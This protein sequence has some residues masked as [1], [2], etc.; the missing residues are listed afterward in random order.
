MSTTSAVTAAYLDHKAAFYDRLIELGYSASAAKKQRQLLAEVADWAGRQ[1]VP[2]EELPSASAEAFFRRRRAR[3]KSNLR[4]PR[5]LEPFLS[6]L[7]HVG[8]VGVSA[9]NTPTD[10]LETFLS[11]YV[12]F[13]RSERGLAPGTARMYS[14]V[15][16]QLASEITDTCGIDWTGLR[17][18]D[19][20]GFATRT[21]KG[22]GVSWSRQVVS[23]LRCLLRYLTL[24]GLTELSLDQAVLSVAGVS[25]PPP[26]GIGPVE[27]EALLKACDRQSAMGRRDY[28]M[29]VLMC[30][31]G[32]RGGEVVR[33][34][35]DDIDWRAG[36]LVV[37]GKGGRRDRLPLLADVGEALSDYLHQGRPPTEDRA[38]FLRCCAPIVG[39]K[40]TGSIRSILAAACIRAGIAY[41][42]PHRL[43]H[44]LATDMLRGG[45]PLRDIGQVLGHQSAAAT[46]VYAKVDFEGLRVVVRQWPEAVA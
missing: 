36:V 46:S 12:T 32:L 3:G 40:A 23:A 45:V 19:V 21:C 1:R 26:Q 8:V 25:P 30:Q 16:R 11:H 44:T 37:V 41:V 20:T 39:L 9:M 28:A 6:Y 13:L 24:E 22:N 27:V 2:L 7:R 17:A 18:G 34:T 5:S 10:P 38:V 35:L 14:R 29:L 4:T 43:R 31:L 33:L 15:A 42:H